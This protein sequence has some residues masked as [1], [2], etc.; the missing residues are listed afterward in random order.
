MLYQLLRE[1][2][3]AIMDKYRAPYPEVLLKLVAKGANKV[4]KDVTVILVVDGLQTLEG[5]G[6]NKESPI[7]RTLATIGDL[8]QKGAFLLPCCT[9]TVSISARQFLAHFSR[10]RVYLPLTPLKPPTILTDGI[11]VPVFEKMI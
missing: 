5:D 8:P 10:L 1:D 11:S 3:G 9:A 4:L 6:H 7:C 2:F